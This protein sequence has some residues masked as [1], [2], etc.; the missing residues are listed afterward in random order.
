M[1][2]TL[3]TDTSTFG[4]VIFEAETEEEANKLMNADPAVA[5]GVMKAQLFPFK[6]V[7]QRNELVS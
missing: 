4:L 6:A 2:R 3:T 7:L 1:G 5:A